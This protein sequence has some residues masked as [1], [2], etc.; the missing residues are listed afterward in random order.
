MMIICRPPRG[1][2][3]IENYLRA[4]CLS[5]EDLLGWVRDNWE[6]HA[7]R[8]VHGLLTQCLS[9]SSKKLREALHTLDGIYELKD[10]SSSSS[11][12]SSSEVQQQQTFTRRLSTTFLNLNKG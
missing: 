11:S 6:S 9:G 7:Y 2:H 4:A 12:S 8:H 1:K 10:S 5:E 3:Y